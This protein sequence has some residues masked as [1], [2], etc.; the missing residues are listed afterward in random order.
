MSAS[1]VERFRVIDTDTHLVEPPDLWTSRMSGRWGDLVPSVRWDAAN[2]EEAWFIGDQRIAPVASAAQAGWG[3]FPPDHP[4]RWSDA[5]P[6]T[7]D[8]KARL[9]RMDEYGIY[10]QVL[11]A[12]VPGNCTLFCS[13]NIPTK[14]NGFSGN[15]WTRTDIAGLDPVLQ[16]VDSNLDESARMA[17]G[18]KADKILADNVASLPIDPLPNI[19]LWSN[20][21]VGPVSDNGILGPF[22]NLAEWGVQS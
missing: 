6:G 19:L 5:D 22:W 16:D 11:T 18:K 3:E 14:D 7:W 1:I 10:A 12:L 2:S 13:G 15:N 17:S 9:A 4:R 21:V 8:A 20:K